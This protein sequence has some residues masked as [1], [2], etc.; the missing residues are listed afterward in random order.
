MHALAHFGMR[1][2]RRHRVVGCDLEPDVEERFTVCGNKLSY[3]VAGLPPPDCDAKDNDATGSNTGRN[4]RAASPLT[5][6]PPP[7]EKRLSPAR[8]A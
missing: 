6:Y 1:N 7:R 8:P 2:D 3:I 5:H 4:E